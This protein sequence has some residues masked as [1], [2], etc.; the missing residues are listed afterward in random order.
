MIKLIALDKVGFRT[1]LK[2]IRNEHT[3]VQGIGKFLAQQEAG[4]KLAITEAKKNSKDIPIFIICRDRVDSLRV[5]VSWLEHRG[6]KNILFIDNDSI[7]PPLIEYFRDTPYQVFPT[8]LNIGHKSPWISGFVKTLVPDGFYVVT[9]PD[10][11][12]IEDCPDDILDRF[13]ELHEE[14]FDYQKIGFGLKIDDLPKEYSLRNSVVEWESQFWKYELKPDVYEAPL[15]TTFALYKPYNY[16]YF[17][18]PSIRTGGKMMARH[19]PWYSDTSKPTN[20]DIFYKKRVDGEITS[21]NMD[22]L[23]D[24]YILEMRKK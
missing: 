23:P 18:T 7:Y 5:L 12:P 9:D 11:I 16:Q 13:M 3:H 10:V 14:F 1:E 20:E 19:M 15:D 2:H 8:K 17:L 21:W 6:L 22:K 4:V 24:R